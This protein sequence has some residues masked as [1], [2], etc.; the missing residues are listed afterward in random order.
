MA[1]TWGG[2]RGENAAPPGVREK[3]L[4]SRGG[5]SSPTPRI[6]SDVRSRQRFPF[7]FRLQARCLRQPVASPPPPQPSA[8]KCRMVCVLGGG[9]HLPSPFILQS[10]SQEASNPR[11]PQPRQ[12]VRYAGRVSGIPGPPR[13]YLPRTAGQLAFFQELKKQM[14]RPPPRSGRGD[15]SEDGASHTDST[16]TLLKGGRRV[17]GEPRNEPPPSARGPEPGRGPHR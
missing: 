2:V 4:H 13:N 14:A 11:L 17:L 3:R 12:D 16:Q 9:D 15:R 7:P 5:G 8:T 10:S 1:V 6:I